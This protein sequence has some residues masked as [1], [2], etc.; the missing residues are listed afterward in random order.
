MTLSASGV[1]EPVYA[2]MLTIGARSGS[3]ESVLGRLSL[4]FFDDAVV[5]MDRLVD[6]VEPALAAFLTIAVGVSTPAHAQQAASPFDPQALFAPL[7][8]PN[9]ANA[10]RDGAGR[11]GSAFWQNRA[12]YSISARIELSY[13]ISM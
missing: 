13:C 3:V 11:P 6:G 1:F 5:K 10:I 7:Q 9:P 8:L 2:R 12:D 4:T